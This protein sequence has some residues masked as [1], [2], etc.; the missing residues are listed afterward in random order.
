LR[1]GG[2]SKEETRKRREE[3]EIGDVEGGD[4]NSRGDK[5]QQQQ[6]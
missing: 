2:E 6:P 4:V 1:G 3:N 5:Q